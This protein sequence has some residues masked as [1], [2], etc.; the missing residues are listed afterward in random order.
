M[1]RERVKAYEDLK[2]ALTSAPL[3]F[4]PDPSKPFKLYVDACME[5]IG[6]ALHQI[7]IVEDVPREGPICFI[8]RQLKES[9]KKYGAS[10][11]ECLCLVWALEKL[12]Y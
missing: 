3:L 6:A 12:Y 4:H 2:L 9:E 8:S 5:G 10:Q 7:Q 11:L 1:T